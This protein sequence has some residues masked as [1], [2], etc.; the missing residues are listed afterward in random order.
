MNQ[1]LIELTKQASEQWKAYF[2]QGDA[3][4]CTSMY[5]KDAQMHAAPF[6]V[7]HGHEQIQAFWQNLIEQGFA[8]VAYFE[9][10]IQC[11][12]ESTTL[13]SSKWTMNKAQGVITKELWVL[14]QD[15]TMRLREDSFEAL[16]PEEA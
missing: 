7:F 10:D 1:Q 5:E 15:G 9:T 13:L 4:G 6:G 8:D 12:D 16:N 2:N 3:A 11:V 14:Q